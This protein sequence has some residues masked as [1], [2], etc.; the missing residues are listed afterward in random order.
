MKRGLIAAVFLVIS[1]CTTNA[2][3]DTG[4]GVRF[5]AP[6]GSGLDV[7]HFFSDV[8][9]IEGNLST[10]WGAFILTGLYEIQKPFES[11]TLSTTHLDYYYG[12]GGHFGNFSHPDKGPFYSESFTTFGIDLILGMEYQFGGIPLAATIDMKPFWSTNSAYS[13]HASFFNFGLGIRYLLG[14]AY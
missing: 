4:I 2:Q 11:A 5:G 1:I 14:S 3:Y 12:I 13:K 7:R 10:G 8:Q 9:A 6:F